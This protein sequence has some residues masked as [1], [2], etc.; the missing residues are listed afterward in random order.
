MSAP[1]RLGLLAAALVL[2]LIN[3]MTTATAER[4]WQN[5]V[6]YEI[7]VRAS[8]TPTATALAT[9][10]ASSS[11]CVPSGA[12][13][14]RNLAH[15]YPRAEL[16]R[17]RR[18][19][20][21]RR[22]PDYGTLDD[23]KELLQAAHALGIRVIIDFVPN[24]SSSRHPWFEAAAASDPAFRDYYVWSADPPDWRGAGGSAWHLNPS[25][26]TTTTSG[27]S[28]PACGPQPP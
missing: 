11:A 27:C 14:E 6:W 21:P 16:P 24:H 25:P 13:R 23:V 1:A 18:H 20:L 19:R 22:Q 4:G 5:G 17:L 9:C 28:R 10:R 26:R 8:R 12:G 7:F 15:A 3:P 2:M